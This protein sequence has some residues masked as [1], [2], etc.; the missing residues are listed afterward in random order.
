DYCTRARWI[1]DADARAH[2]E[3]WLD[4]IEEAAGRKATERDYIG[5]GEWK[6]LAKRIGVLPRKVTFKATPDFSKLPSPRKALRAFIADTQRVGSRLLF[7]AA[8]E[9]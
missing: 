6:K 8:V 9:D 3:S 4:R 5:R 1:A 2:A 7:V